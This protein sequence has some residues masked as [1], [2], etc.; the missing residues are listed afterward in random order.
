MAMTSFQRARELTN[1]EHAD[2]P[3]RLSVAGVACTAAL[4]TDRARRGAHRAHVAVQTI[5]F[6][7]T[8]S[9]EL[10]K[11]KRD[12][13]E[14]E[15]L[16]AHL[17]LNHLAEAC[18]VEER[19]KLG[20]LATEQLQTTRTDARADW[21][22]LVLGTIDATCLGPS[23][24]GD[25]TPA[26]D[27]IFP[28]AFNPLHE[29]HLRMAAVAQQLVRSPVEFE[30]SIQN[31]DKPPLDYTEIA[32]RAGQFNAP[33][34][35]WLTCAARFVDKSAIFPGA[36]LIVGA[37]TLLRIA[38]PRY[39]GNDLDACRA[40]IET[41]ANRSCRF[42]VFGRS[43]RAGFQTLSDLQLPDQLVSLCQEV[44]ED[45]FREDISST[46]LRQP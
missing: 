4:A 41:F 12:R 8:V 10:E 23:P 46:E 17:T 14:E 31:V 7:S 29:G 26:A 19:I 34:A 2:Q 45:Q 38:D 9:L 13:A 37:D 18:Q 5:D 42:L 3:G 30:L 25:D 22:D 36:T 40:A 44:T 28:G 43:G 1:D 21:R 35:L 24:P 27:V 11:G 16:V 33:Q 39:Y 20:L 15:R 32:Q 6:T